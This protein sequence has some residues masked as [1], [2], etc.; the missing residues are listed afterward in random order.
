MIDNDNQNNKKVKSNSSPKDAVVK[1]SSKSTPNS[2]WSN[3]SFINNPSSSKRKKTNKPSKTQIIVVASPEPTSNRF[4]SLDVDPM[5][6]NDVSLPIPSTSQNVNI[7]N[8]DK[9]PQL[10][11]IFQE[12]GK[13]IWS[14]WG[15]RLKLIPL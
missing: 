11:Y 14:P 7:K 8:N 6:T 10:L 15:K 3:D 13:L 1:N 9:P 5:E 2:D 12:I 4:D